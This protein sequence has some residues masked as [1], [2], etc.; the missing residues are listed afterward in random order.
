[1]N[2]QTSARHDG[3]RGR[4]DPIGV[5]F[6][7]FAVALVSGVVFALRPLAPILSLGVLYL[8]AV[9]AVAVFWGLAYA[10]AA[11]VA[12]L[13]AFNFLFLPP[14]YTLALRDSE[15]WAALAVYLVTAVVVSELAARARRRSTEAEQQRL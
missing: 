7:L 6:S 11:S 5:L 2:T 8:F 15:S 4:I 9:L 10:L 14:V 13:L 12:S 1:V 3:R